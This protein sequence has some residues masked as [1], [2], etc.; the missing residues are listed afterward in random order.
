MAELK[1]DHPVPDLTEQEDAE[2]LAAIAEGIEQLEAGQGIPME[3]LR[4]ELAQRCSK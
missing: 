4:K 3:E 2:T 1:F